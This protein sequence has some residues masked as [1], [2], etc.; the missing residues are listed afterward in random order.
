MSKIFFIFCMSSKVHSLCSLG[1]IFNSS[2]VISS[3]CLL[4]FLKDANHQQICFD[5]VIPER[6]SSF[7]FDHQLFY[8]LHKIPVVSPQPENSCHPQ[9]QIQRQHHWPTLPQKC[10]PQKH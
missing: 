2:I 6:L 8:Y 9:I 4:D 3:L 5:N 7:V 1:E 10:P